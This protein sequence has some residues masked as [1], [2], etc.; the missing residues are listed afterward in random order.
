MGSVLIAPITKN[1]SDAAKSKGQQRG[2]V[3][4]RAVRWG[5]KRRQSAGQVWFSSSAL[6]LTR[7]TERGRGPN[8]HIWFWEWVDGRWY[9]KNQSK[10]ER[11][12]SINSPI[13]WESAEG[14]GE[15]KGVFF[16]IWA[17]GG[18]LP[19]P[20]E[21]PSHFQGRLEKGPVFGG[22][23]ARSAPR[24]CGNSQSKRQHAAVLIVGRDQEAREEQ[25]GPCPVVWTGLQFVP[26]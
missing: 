3:R 6:V 10:D 25:Q 13:S 20:E 24:L 26:R 17:A 18:F 5:L 9:P 4:K 2:N 8:H 22:E 23:I 7:G 12:K 15:G 19:R 21:Q 11:W 1:T 16:G 14:D